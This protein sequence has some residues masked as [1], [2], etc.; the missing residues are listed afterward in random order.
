MT[1]QCKD[2]M[3]LRMYTVSLF[4]PLMMLATLRLFHLNILDIKQVKDQQLPGT[5]A[6]RTKIPPSNLKWEITKITISQN[7]KR[8]CGKPN[9]QLSPKRWPLS[10][11]NLT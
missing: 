8:T 9:E 5:G 3:P 1:V 4:S 11:L 2:Q 10:Y 7:T 6:I